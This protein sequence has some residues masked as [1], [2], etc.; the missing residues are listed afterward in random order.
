MRP[1]PRAIF[2]RSCAV[3]VIAVTTSA[4]DRLGVPG[5]VEMLAYPLKESDRMRPRAVERFD[6]LVMG[7]VLLG[8]SRQNL[9]AQRAVLFSSGEGGASGR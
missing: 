5:S 8:D 3:G 7:H 9:F 1:G 6:L 4:D 2:R